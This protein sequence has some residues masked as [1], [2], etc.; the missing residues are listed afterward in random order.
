MGRLLRLQL[1]LPSASDFIEEK[2][3]AIITELID[4]LVWGVIDFI[5]S[6]SFKLAPQ[7]KEKNK[8]IRNKM[9]LKEF[10]QQK[11][12][13]GNESNT[14]SKKTTVPMKEKKIKARK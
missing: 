8:I 14:S 1:Y 9:K 13:E 4:L 10:E 11:K 2:D 5:F 7:V 12:R 6:S 3:F